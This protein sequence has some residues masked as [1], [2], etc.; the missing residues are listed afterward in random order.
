MRD[1]KACLVLWRCLFHYFVKLSFKFCRWHFKQK[2]SL[3]HLFRGHE[4]PCDDVWPIYSLIQWLEHSSGPYWLQYGCVKIYS[5]SVISILY[6]SARPLLVV[7]FMVKLLLIGIN[8]TISGLPM[9]LRVFSHPIK[10][11][12]CMASF[13]AF[14]LAFLPSLVKYDP[15]KQSR[16][17]LER[18]ETISLEM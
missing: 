15:E 3:N 1:I 4:L 5:I 2:E 18:L 14:S 8:N 9:S 13:V 7:Q 17:F 16:D 6:S 11:D 10:L 12:L